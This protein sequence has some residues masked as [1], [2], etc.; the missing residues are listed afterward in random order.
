MK[1]VVFNTTT[2]VLIKQLQGLFYLTVLQAQYSLDVFS[3][4]GLVSIL[5]EK[6][7][8]R[9][10]FFIV[11]YYFLVYGR[12]QEFRVFYGTALA[13]VNLFKEAIDFLRR[14]FAIEI[15]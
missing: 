11:Q 3:R 13:D 2:L 9:L 5:I 14:Q 7:K 4:Y 6:I 10:Y 1:L 12:H 15:L 8:C